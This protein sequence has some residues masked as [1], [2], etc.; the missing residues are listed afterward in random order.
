MEADPPISSE[1]GLSER[2]FTPR[3]PVSI[4]GGKSK[5]G[6]PVVH[7]SGGNVPSYYGDFAATHVAESS[8]SMA[9]K[10]LPQET[11]RPEVLDYL[12]ASET[13]A[14]LVPDRGVSNSDGDTSGPSLLDP[15]GRRLHS[16]ASRETELEFSNYQQANNGSTINEEGRRGSRG[17]LADLRDRFGKAKAVEDMSIEV[18]FSRVS[19]T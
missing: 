8:S 3:I 11:S 14:R 1:K 9:I 17:I 7:V 13:V 5:T 16:S 2:F 18:I 4:F 10:A 15:P 19:P 6:K 12:P